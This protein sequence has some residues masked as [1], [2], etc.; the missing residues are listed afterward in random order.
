MENRLLIFAAQDTTSTSLSRLLHVLAFN[1]PV[2][3]RL[4][5]EILDAQSKYIRE[6]TYDEV[7]AL[8]YLDAV[9][10]ETLRL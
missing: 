3:E 9:I 8:P 2:Q 7:M 1:P 6:M 10:R 4:R 5:S